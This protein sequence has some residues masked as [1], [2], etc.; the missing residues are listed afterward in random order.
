M[1]LQRRKKY[2]WG[3]LTM[4]KRRD[5]SV[6]VY[7][8]FDNQVNGNG[9]R[10]RLKFIVGRTDEMTEDDAWFEIE[11][12]RMAANAERPAGGSV[13]MRG[14]ID[15]YIREILEPC[16]VPLGGV[17]SEIARMS[18]SNARGYRGELRNWVEP[19][20]GMHDVREFERPE[21]RTAVEQWLPTIVRSAQNPTGREISAMRHVYNAMRQVFKWGVKWGHINFNPLAD[22][23]VELPSGAT[24]QLHV[25]KPPQMTP[26]QF[27]Y[28]LDN[29]EML[30]KV[31]SAVEGWLGS[32]R[33]E[34][35]G[36]KWEDTN[37]KDGIVNFR[38]GWVN[39]RITFLKTKASRTNLPIPPE[40]L[41]LLREWRKVTPFNAPSDWIFASPRR[42]GK[43]PLDPQSLM[44]NH[45]RPLALK[46][47]LPRITWYSFRHSASQWAKSALPKAQ[48]AKELL[49][50]EKYSTTSELYGGMSIDEKRVI[51]DELV[52]YMRRKAR[53]EAVKKSSDEKRSRKARKAS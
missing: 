18:D 33:S 11:H 22:D 31:A 53:S 2:Q 23:L 47:G 25:K 32:R 8:Y 4:E 42:N 41:K 7:R 30:P 26:A 21:I 6:W 27:F 34:G 28:L 13:T 38:R 20:W 15:R 5:H 37:L 17:Q 1:N 50:H 39:G 3:T 44:K 29:A 51:Q 24:T 43:R 14:L 46:L 35:F 12:L 10:K 40:L 48:D 16:F 52:Q 49:R 36:L 45:I 19:R 9:K